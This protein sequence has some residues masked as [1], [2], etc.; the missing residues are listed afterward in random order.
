MM[1]S[2]VQTHHLKEKARQINPCALPWR[3][4]ENQTWVTSGCNRGAD[5]WPIN[6]RANRR[7]L[8]QRSITLLSV[9]NLSN[10]MDKHGQVKVMAD[11]HGCCS[12]FFI[13]IFKL[14]N[15]EARRSNQYTGSLLVLATIFDWL[16]TF[17]RKIA[18]VKKYLSIIV[19]NQ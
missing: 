11:W 4:T 3:M 12:F 1:M 15:T 14:R 18:K 16:S 17:D 6:R 7:H 19:G 13:L 10:V 8:Q 5:W 9:W 2:I